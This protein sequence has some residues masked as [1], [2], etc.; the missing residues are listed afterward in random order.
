LLSITLCKPI[1]YL[2]LRVRRD[3]SEIARLARLLELR[4]DER[5]TAGSTGLT[6]TADSFLSNDNTLS[7]ETL[8]KRLFRTGYC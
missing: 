8:K 6:C 4:L 2:A 5:V 1:R 3:M 7:V